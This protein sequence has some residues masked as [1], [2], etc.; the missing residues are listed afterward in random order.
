VDSHQV[1]TSR[2]ALRMVLFCE[3]GRGTS[4]KETDERCVRRGSLFVKKEKTK[5]ETDKVRGICT[6]LHSRSASLQP[7]R[8]SDVEPRLD[9]PIQL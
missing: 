6:V 9:A 5:D 2:R 1:V 7:L 3:T 4:V 8:A